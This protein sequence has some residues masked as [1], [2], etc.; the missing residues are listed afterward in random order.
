MAIHHANRGIVKKDL[1][2]YYNREFSKSFRGEATSNLIM[3]PSDANYYQGFYNFTVTANAAIAPDGS[4]N[5]WSLAWNGT[6]FNYYSK[7]F[8]IV[9]S[10][11][12]TTSVF[13]KAGTHNVI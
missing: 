10:T 2:L 12:Y 11:V 4:N 8:P 7:N 5:A 9:N 3:N 13:A 6:D 1:Q